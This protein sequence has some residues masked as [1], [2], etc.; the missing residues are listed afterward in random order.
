MDADASRS[1][2]NNTALFLFPHTFFRQYYTR[3]SDPDFTSSWICRLICKFVKLTPSDQSFSREQ[4]YMRMFFLRS[5]RDS[6]RGVILQIYK[7][8]CISSCQ[9]ETFH[10]TPR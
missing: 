10:D 4:K 5:G 3:V 6:E 8:T 1:D 9:E 7:S 2:D